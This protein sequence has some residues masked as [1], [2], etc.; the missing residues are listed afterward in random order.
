M[1]Q[2]EKAKAYDKA[3][4]TAKYWTEN[5]TVWSSDDVCQK[6]F[7]EL[8]ESK[9]EKIRKWLLDF[10]QGLP[11]EGLDFHFYNLNKKQVLAWL[12][13]QGEQKP[14]WSEEDEEEFN[15]ALDMI[16]WYSGKNEK[17]VRLVSDWL[18]SLKERLGG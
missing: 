6:L 13:K 11:D 9:D 14:A 16:E 18:K 8:T 10:V 4:E 7:P 15:Y 1:T 3:L 2:E 12:E 17:R 5:P